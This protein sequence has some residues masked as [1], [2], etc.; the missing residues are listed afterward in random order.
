M[1]GVSCTPKVSGLILVRGARTRQPICF[2]FALMSLSHLPF[3]LKSVN[4]CPQM[5]I[6]KKTQEPELLFPGPPPGSAQTGS[7]GGGWGQPESWQVKRQEAARHIAP[8]RLPPASFWSVLAVLPVKWSGWDGTGGLLGLLSSF[9]LLSPVQSEL[10]QPSVLSP[11]PWITSLPV[12][13]RTGLFGAQRKLSLSHVSYSF[14]LCLL[15]QV[16]SG[17]SGGRMY[18]CLFFS[19]LVNRCLFW[20]PAFSFPRTP[21][22]LTVPSSQRPCC[23]VTA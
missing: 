18:L 22:C 16:F 4:I 13:V 20:P 2:S 8:A 7:T 5:R 12:S 6:L 10:L 23:V 11:L 15:P 14:S 17:Q 1:V 19:S 21:L 9:M 3:S